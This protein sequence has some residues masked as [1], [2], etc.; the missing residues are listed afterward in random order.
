MSKSLYFFKYLLF[1]FLLGILSIYKLPVLIEMINNNYHISYIP[2]SFAYLLL[3]I[4]CLFCLFSKK[5]GWYQFIIFLFFCAFNNLFEI[6]TG[7]VVFMPSFSLSGIVTIVQ[8]SL[9]IFPI[10]I[11]AGWMMISSEG[12]WI[13]TKRNKFILLMISLALAI[14]N[15]LII[16]LL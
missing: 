2:P 8:D 10:S 16:W 9:I 5:L 1:Y 11:V 14:I 15:L 12:E 4:G 6:I 13:I 7:L 3:L